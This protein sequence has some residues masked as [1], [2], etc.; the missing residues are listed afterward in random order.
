LDLDDGKILG[1]SKFGPFGG[2]PRA[3]E[4]IREWEPFL[5]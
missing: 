1:G 4:R 3:G 5:V 2:N